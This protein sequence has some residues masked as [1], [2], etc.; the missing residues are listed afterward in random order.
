MKDFR[1]V[2]KVSKTLELNEIILDM[3]ILPHEPL[4]KHDRSDR[5]NQEEPQPVMLQE[6]Q[7]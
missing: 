7:N 1:G 2:E 3:I 4:R 5:I 6:L